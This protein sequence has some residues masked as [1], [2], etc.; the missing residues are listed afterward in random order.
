MSGPIGG[1]IGNFVKA[2]GPKAIMQNLKK[3]PTA[4]ISKFK[5]TK[6]GA[7]VNLHQMKSK[8]IKESLITGTGGT[9]ASWLTDKDGNFTVKEALGSFIGNA[10]GGGLGA[11]RGLLAPMADDAY[12]AF[13]KFAIEGSGFMLGGKVEGK[14]N[15]N[16]TTAFNDLANFFFGGF[17]G[18]IQKF[19]S[20]GLGHVTKFVP[21]T[22][23]TENLR[24]VAEKTIINTIILSA[25]NHAKV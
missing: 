18:P 4:M 19:V 25:R 5:A 22:P 13:S 15:G 24:D 20:A 2:V 14:I 23:I 11:G 8:A 1:T 7:Q 9:F 3:A 17:G 12:K 10:I 21:V 16:V 6:W